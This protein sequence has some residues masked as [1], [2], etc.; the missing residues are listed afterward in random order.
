MP[1][2]IGYSN[3]HVSI[4]FIQFCLAHVFKYSDI[5][6]S[7]SYLYLHISYLY[8]VRNTLIAYN[9]VRTSW[10]ASKTRE[11]SLDVVGVRVFIRRSLCNLRLRGL[12]GRHH[13]WP[14]GSPSVPPNNLHIH[15]CIHVFISVLKSSYIYLIP[16]HFHPL[17]LHI[18]IFSYLPTFIPSYLISHIISHSYSSA[19]AP[20]TVFARGTGALTRQ[21]LLPYDLIPHHS[22]RRLPRVPRAGHGHLPHARRRRRSFG[23]AAA[24]GRL[25]RHFGRIVYFGHHQVENQQV[26]CCRRQARGDRV[27]DGPQC[28]TCG[29]AQDLPAWKR[30]G[31][32]E[33]PRGKPV[34]CVVA[35]A[36]GAGHVVLFRGRPL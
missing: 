3:C 26:S 31:V 33:G 5:L 23:A 11:A 14:P 15:I 28:G 24:P 8:L 9:C 18:F 29:V 7:Y 25:R 21:L 4:V 27:G 22:R 34:S 6:I 35:R 17:S 1:R 19:F 30:H 32:Q 2:N 20:S 12:F 13:N 36:L 16:S 10:F